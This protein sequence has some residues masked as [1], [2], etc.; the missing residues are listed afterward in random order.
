MKMQAQKTSLPVPNTSGQTINADL[1]IESKPLLAAQVQAPGQQLAPPLRAA[2]EEAPQTVHMVG[3]YSVTVQGTLAVA[4]A[5]G[6]APIPLT[7]NTVVNIT[8]DT[9]LNL[10]RHSPVQI[11]QITSENEWMGDC[12]RSGLLTLNG[13]GTL[14]V[15]SP[16]GNAVD[17]WGLTVRQGAAL[18]ASAP[19]TGIYAQYYMDVYDSR[20]NARGGVNG[21]QTGSYMVLHTKSDIQ[22]TG[23]QDG[24]SVGTLL[25]V[26]SGSQLRAEGSRYGIHTKS[27]INAACLPENVVLPKGETP[28]AVYG[29]GG[30]R[31]ILSRGSALA[32][33]YIG[34]GHIIAHTNTRIVG[35]AY[36]EGSIGIETA[37][38]ISDGYIKAFG[39]QVQGTGVAGGIRCNSAGYILSAALL[40]KPGHLVGTATGAD[41]IGI[42]STLP[43]WNA[44][45]IAQENST[46]TGNG[47][48]HGIKSVNGDIQ[49]HTGATITA[50]SSQLGQGKPAVFSG[51]LAAIKPFSAEALAVCTG[52]TIHE[53]YQNAGIHFNQTPLSPAMAPPYN[54]AIGRSMKNTALY[55]WQD[56]LRNFEDT[57]PA[58]LVALHADGSG[59]VAVGPAENLAVRAT[60]T[61]NTG[62]SAPY[63]EP[64]H[65]PPGTKD[66][67]HM[68]TLLGNAADTGGNETISLLM[69][70]SFLLENEAMRALNPGVGPLQIVDENVAFTITNAQSGSKTVVC[71]GTCGVTLFEYL[72]PGTYT[73]SGGV[74]DGYYP[75][76]PVVFTLNAAREIVVESGRAAVVEGHLEIEYSPR[77][78]PH[79][80]SLV[81]RGSPSTRLG[82]SF[83]L[84][85]RAWQSV[86]AG[87]IHF[88]TITTLPGIL[89]HGDAPGLY[90][91]VTGL[92]PRYAQWQFAQQPTVAP[93]Y[94]LYEE[95]TSVFGMEKTDTGYQ[96]ANIGLGSGHHHFWPTQRRVEVT[97]TFN[98][99]RPGKLEVNVTAQRV[100]NPHGQPVFL[101]ELNGISGSAAGQTLYAAAT[102][103]GADKKQPSER[104]ATPTHGTGTA[105]FTGLPLGTYAVTAYPTLRFARGPGG[106]YTKQINI[107][108]QA[109]TPKADFL[110]AATNLTR[111]FGTDADAH[112]P[113]ISPAVL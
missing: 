36:E 112:K 111:Y 68:V 77:L 90:D 62:L 87:L 76:G 29:R 88:P 12:V 30:Q 23:G 83:T 113:S 9:V 66:N 63:A 20:L 86:Y 100:W 81:E 103:P 91:A 75:P 106:V 105:T 16:S 64:V 11:R 96:M 41:G 70:D 97:N 72:R 94:F 43:A 57:T 102:L 3:T 74:V 48:R 52:A 78:V 80:V 59:L 79:T 4:L 5:T 99:E 71:S 7:P 82:G 101:V 37:T 2:T 18:E 92:H 47:A 31:G 110:F 51:K 93:A 26:L 22:A 45:I 54:T 44:Y 98:Q 27:Y 108:P 28:S 24:L 109:L 15:D 42:E 33:G 17:V 19:K 61:Q 104:L 58:G 25:E 32:G 95:G 55:T 21:I 56:S 85:A 84:T 10:G 1:Q 14:V 35:E 65:I 53:I 40:G 13:P 50:I 39:G 8:G 60:R 67:T 38:N 69:Q 89:A 6:G 73:I 107:M 49:A 34:G 46:L